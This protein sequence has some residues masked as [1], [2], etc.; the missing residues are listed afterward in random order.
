[1]GDVACCCT[2]QSGLRFELQERAVAEDSRTRMDGH[3]SLVFLII[4]LS[5]EI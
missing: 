1:M 4:C 5:G 2:G 3:I